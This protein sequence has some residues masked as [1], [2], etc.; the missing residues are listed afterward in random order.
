ME[1]KL[2]NFEI[3]FSYEIKRTQCKIIFASM[4]KTKISSSHLWTYEKLKIAIEKINFLTRSSLLS[5]GF[6]Q[7]NDA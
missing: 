7:R 1:K 3:F 6:T 5:G 4:E 2:G